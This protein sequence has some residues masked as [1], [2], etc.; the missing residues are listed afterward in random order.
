MVD[1]AGRVVS[2]ADV[3]GE[4][5]GGRLFGGELSGGR[6]SGGGVAGGCVG[7]GSGSGSYSAL[8]SSASGLGSPSS[9]IKASMPPALSA[10]TSAPSRVKV[11][12]Q[13]EPANAPPTPWPAPLRPSVVVGARL[14]RVVESG[15]RR[16]AGLRAQ[17][18]TLRAKA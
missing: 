12:L 8:L 18:R 14:K 7:S 13:V 3:G 11:L 9:W 16:S 1:I 4:L 5:F 6:L 15:H 17:H 10:T 2:G